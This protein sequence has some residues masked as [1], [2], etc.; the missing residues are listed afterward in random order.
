MNSLV[1]NQR[2]AVKVV[3]VS[4]R[5]RICLTV[6]SKLFTDVKTLLWTHWL[7]YTMVSKIQ[8]KFCNFLIQSW[9][10]RRNLDHRFDWMN[11][12]SNSFKS[13]YT[14]VACNPYILYNSLEL[15][16]F[17]QMK[18]FNSVLPTLWHGTVWQWSSW[19]SFPNKCSLKYGEVPKF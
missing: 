17:L 15:W 6:Y 11:S 10:S 8:N 3:S 14:N 2:D 7:T 1:Y 13:T 12:F 18:L 9:R 16:S 19:M 5:S 4:L